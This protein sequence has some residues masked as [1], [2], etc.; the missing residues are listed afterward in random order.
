MKKLSKIDEYILGAATLIENKGW[1]RGTSE[2]LKGRHCIY[3]AISKQTTDISEKIKCCNKI[4]RY[5][6]FPI[7][8][9]VTYV[10][11]W[12]DHEVNNKKEVIDTLVGSVYWNK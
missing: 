6:D 11:D 10:I 1:T 12:N 8:F 5:L 3:G 4:S 9:S 2:D 7:V